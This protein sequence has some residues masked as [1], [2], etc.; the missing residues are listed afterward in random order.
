MGDL[1][2]VDMSAIPGAM[3]IEMVVGRLLKEVNALRLEVGQLKALIKIPDAFSRDEAER[4][5]GRESGT[6]ASHD[7]P[8]RRIEHPVRH[9]RTKKKPSANQEQQPRQQRP[10]R[11]TG[12]V[13]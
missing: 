1:A 4:L 9:R 10:V 12:S 7:Q 3:G 5:L 6:P 13:E 2:D 11:I 8:V